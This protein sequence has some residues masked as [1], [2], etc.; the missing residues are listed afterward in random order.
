[1]PQRISR[2]DPRGA[3][4]WLPGSYTDA[5]RAQR[6]RPPVPSHFVCSGRDQ[7]EAGHDPGR[8]CDMGEPLWRGCDVDEPIPAP[9]SVT[10]RVPP[11]D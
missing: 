5:A 8:G 3:G 10:H 4:L 6:N 9:R 1:M 7:W 2:L 11:R